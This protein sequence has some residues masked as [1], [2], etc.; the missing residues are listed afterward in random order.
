MHLGVIIKNEEW[1]N[2]RHDRNV[3]GA[4]FYCV[5]NE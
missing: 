1:P 2:N 5:I 4:D 3:N